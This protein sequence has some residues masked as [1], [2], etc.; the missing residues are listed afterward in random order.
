MAESATQVRAGRAADTGHE[1]GFFSKLSREWTSPDRRT[2]YYMIAPAVLLIVAIAFFPMIYGVML[3]FQEIVPNQPSQWVGLENYRSIFADTDFRTGLL[4][5]SIFTVASV[6][7]EFLFGLLIA[8]GLN[9]TFKGQGLSRGIALVPWAFPTAVSALMWRLMYQDAGIMAYLAEKLGY[10]GSI[11][12]SDGALLVAAI[13]VDVWK[14][15]PFMAILML[16][17]LQVI[18]LD[19]YEAARVDGATTMQTFWR[20]TLPLLKPAILVALLFRTLDSWRVFD[21]FYVMG[22]NQLD[23]L[24][25][26]VFEGVRV[27]QLE[28]SLGNAAAV[29]IF[30]SS[31]AI[32]AVFIKVLGARAQEG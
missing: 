27:S 19:V 1:P 11:L 7:F 31:L 17:G 6:S 16:A 4:N 15:T 28:I 26:Y 8:L 12:T 9:R 3:S 18:P 20:I 21:L 32:A 25:T 14:T 24:S 29:F 10:Q 2:A 30:L 5:T 22:G 13:I 23:S